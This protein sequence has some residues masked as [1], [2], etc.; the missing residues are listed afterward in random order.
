MTATLRVGVGMVLAL[1]FGGCQSTS[2]STTPPPEETTPLDITVEA[3]TRAY[4]EA[5]FE[6]ENGV[7]HGA[8]QDPDGFGGYTTALGDFL[9]PR[10]YMTYVGLTGEVEKV[11]EWADNLKAEL[12]SLPGGV[13]PQVGLNMTGG[14]DDGSGQV[15]DVAEGTYEAQI[16]AFI[17]GLKALERPVYVRIGY[18][19]EG[20][21]NGYDPVGY[22]AA[23]IKITQAMRE[24][25]LPV[26]TVWC[27]GGGSANFMAWEDMQAYYPGDEWVDW[28]GIDIFSPEE[29][30]NPALPRFLTRA[31]GHQKPVMIG[32]TTPRYVGVED[33]A[34]SWEKWFQPFF[35][36]VY[37]SPQIK[38]ICYINWD[39]YYWSE[40]LGFEWHDWK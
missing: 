21:W 19:F 13:Y 3:T 9:H 24:A 20:S 16:E 38:A 7:L 1:F 11:S 22:V 18:E 15:G 5:R 34:V 14:N 36:T 37:A 32:E 10:I 17:K 30:S 33:G 27:S 2:T 28:W 29:W 4:Y 26:A 23:F 25:E 35:E 12:A 31:D 39:W 40:K 8:G 6:P